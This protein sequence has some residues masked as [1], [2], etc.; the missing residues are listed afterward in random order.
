[1]KKTLL[2][3][4]L[5]AIMPWAS[6]ARDARGRITSTIIAD[7]LA[8]LP[9]QNGQGYTSVMADIASTGAEG[10]IQIADMLVPAD[11]GKNAPV[12]HAL[13]GLVAY[14]TA[15]GHEAERDLVREGLKTAIDKCTD[16][17]NKAFLMTLLQNCGTADDAPFFAKY[18]T[19]KYLQEWVINA[20]IAIPGTESALMELVAT[21]P[22]PRDVL[23]Y[24]VGKKGLREAEPIILK[25]IAD[26]KSNDNR[27]YYK[28]LGQIGSAK[29]IPV[30][31]KAAKEQ[32]YAWEP[33]AATEAYVTL[34]ENMAKNGDSKR[35]VNAA[36]ALL[37]AT[38]RTNVR[39]AALNMIFAAEG[40]KALPLLVK[41]MNEPDRAYRVNALRR[42]EDWAD[43]EVYTTLNKFITAKTDNETKAD[44][45][46]WYGTNHVVDQIDVILPCMNSS[47]AEVAEAA[48]MAAGKI[49]GDKALQALVSQLGGP[50]SDVATAALLAFNGKVNPGIM[51]ALGDDNAGRQ[52][53]AL[54]VASI[55]KMTEATPII[56]ELASSDNADLKKAACQ[57][58]PGVVLPKD[59]DDICQLIEQNDANNNAALT[60]ALRSSVRN[61][62]ETEQYATVIPYINRSKVPHLY[63][64][65]LAQ[66]ATPEA[67][68]YLLQAYNNGTGVEKEMAIDALLNVNEPEMIDVLYNIA[69]NDRAYAA[70]ALSRYTALVNGSSYTPEEKYLFYRKALESS[71][72]NAIKSDLLK[73]MATTKTYQALMLADKY[74]SDK[75]TT[76]AAANAVRTILTKNKMAFGGAP[77]RKALEH[78]RE[79]FKSSTD[80]DDGY[81]VDDIN[82]ML[83]KLPEAAF[84]PLIS[85]IPL[86]PKAASTKKAKSAAEKSFKNWIVNDGS[87]TYTGTEPSTVAF[88][89][90]YENF[91]MIAEWRGDGHF[92]VRSIPD[93]A[94]GDSKANTWSTIYIKVVNDRITV[95]ENGST[96]INNEMMQNPSDPSK[97]I[98]TSGMI[99]LSSNGSP[100]EFR[101]IYVRELPA[102]PICELSADEVADGFK[103]LFDG[104]SMHNFTGNTT[105]YIPV[106][107]NICV[108]AQ[109]GNGSNLYTKEEY[110]NFILRFEFCFD[111]EGVNNGVGIRT[112]M[113]VDAAYHGMEIQILDHDAPIYK[114][115]RDYQVH[116]SVYGIIPAKRIKH[117]ALGEWSTEEIRAVGDHITV[118]VNGETIL[119]GNIRDA[120]QGH[121]MAPDGSDNN[122]NTVDHHNHPGLFNKSGHIGFLGHGEGIKFRNIRIKSLK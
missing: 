23:A 11:K 15:S 10:V 117:K 66:A 103:L 77:V 45:I 14:A 122:P 31:A 81:A 38:D 74:F 54:K 71:D 108:S 63:Y 72:N 27:A 121:N 44:I 3:L 18:V 58:L 101:D 75:A 49:G 102:T 94:G 33:N 34:L 113:G 109:Y 59:F 120:C 98:N 70:K 100:V 68:N 9:A 84:M 43:A 30:L 37:K 93:I 40:K 64:M 4:I 111:K 95:V 5:A 52:T 96:I 105:N 20:L 107:G 89:K 56:L 69:I 87:I 99:M 48:I 116:G 104:R 6:T 13:S 25:W 78:A 115:L 119:D 92:G 35:A 41:A 83:N 114:D 24:A 67:I 7:A 29:S 73:S 8:Q 32:K 46:N 85:N 28:A 76:M 53:A 55:R 80:P 79:A 106:D 62:P 57:A 36:K 90:P 97:P 60:S 42:A 17:P 16:N 12:E 118:T 86:V 22:I 47:D 88:D 65:V 82:Q 112:P 26:A 39:S 91:E 19:D 110:S 51:E 21:E 2:F 61:L 1:M 50:K